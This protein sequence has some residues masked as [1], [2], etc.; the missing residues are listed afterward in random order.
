MKL[1]DSKEYPIIME[2]DDKVFTMPNIPKTNDGYIDAL[3]IILNMVRENKP[4]ETKL[5]FE[6][7]NSKINLDEACVRLNPMKLVEK[8]ETGWKLPETSVKWLE[9]EDN[10]FLAS[11]LCA[12]IRFLA[13]VLFYL[14]IP[15][16]SNEL[17]SIAVS[18]Y[19]MTWKSIQPLHKRLVWLRELELIDFHHFSLEYFITDLGKEFLKTVKVVEPSDVVRDFDKTINEDSIVISDWAREYYYNSKSNIRRDTL[20][21]F[22][23]NISEIGQTL[24]EVLSYIRSGA[25]YDDIIEFFVKKYKIAVS[26]VKHFMSNLANHNFV[27]RKTDTIFELTNLAI[28]W[29]QTESILDFV[30][31]LQVTNLF[32]IELLNEIKL[33]P[34]SYKELAS[35]A[36]V[37]YGFNKEK[38]NDIR[39]RITILKK[40]KLVM[41]ASADKYTLT[42]RGQMLLE[43]FPELKVNIIKEVKH[44][45]KDKTVEIE[46]LY[47]ELRLSSKDS[48]NPTRFEKAVES[49]FKEIGFSTELLGGSGNTD[50]LLKAPG[51]NSFKVAVDAKS[52][53][54]GSIND[55]LVDFDTLK[56]HKKKHKADYMAIVGCAFKQERL[57]AR[58]IEHNVVL[59]DIDILEDLVKK[60]KETP[61]IVKTYKQIFEQK[62]IADISILDDD[63]K[64]I[65]RDGSLMKAVIECLLTESM[66]VVT[67]GQ[68]QE[69][70]IYRSLRDNPIF[71]EGIELKEIA[72][73]LQFLSSP[74]IGCLG[75]DK[76]YYYAIASLEDV[77]KKLEFLARACNLL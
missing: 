62:G 44:S 77:A 70:D 43:L 3:R 63:R 26:S 64:R 14:D 31:C 52:T 48:S 12:N 58:A 49:A 7:S 33:E 15:R 20:G 13:E 19:D 54:S 30:V 76:D 75:K 28:N 68:L 22:P 53:S 66:D 1:V 10:L 56:E 5:S 51:A 71:K 74:L 21:Y 8:R 6:G 38:I 25:Q 24:S 57:I 27:V 47:N 17:L 16:T 23:G 41:N 4:K 46:S 35:K 36:K 34:M 42:H 61:L 50:V 59:L 9:S 11:I 32:V 72:N 2:W 29:L 40:A 67:K 55:G 39:Q 69:R 18:E 37:Y 60:H 65:V 45:S 73:M